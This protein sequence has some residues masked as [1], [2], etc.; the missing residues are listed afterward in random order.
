LASLLAETNA[1]GSF[2]ATWQVEQGIEVER[3]SKIDLEV[4]KR[5]GTV[6]RI[7]IGGAGAYVGHGEIDVKTGN[8]LPHP[9]IE[10][11]R[12]VARDAVLATS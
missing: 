10:P 3:P 7:R 12:S 5:S 6:N 2:D 4:D 1:R 11:G 8:G 9:Q